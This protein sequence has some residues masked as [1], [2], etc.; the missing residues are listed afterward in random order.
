MAGLLRFNKN[1]GIDPINIALCGN[2]LF[3]VCVSLDNFRPPHT[4]VLAGREGACRRQM[5]PR[6]MPLFTHTFREENG[7]ISR[8]W[9]SVQVQLVLGSDF[10]KVYRVIPVLEDLFYTSINPFNNLFH[11]V[12]HHLVVDFPVRKKNSEMEIRP[13]K[14]KNSGTVASSISDKFSLP[15]EKSLQAE[16]MID[17]ENRHKDFHRP[18]AH[19]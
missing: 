15:S 7:S 9:G 19:V 5:A 2:V 11:K 13:R 6:V 10:M 14:S 18:V 12:S 3:F 16:A 4:C 8:F 17:G 1:P